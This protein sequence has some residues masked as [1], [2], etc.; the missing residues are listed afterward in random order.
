MELKDLANRIGVKN[1][2]VTH[3]NNLHY[4]DYVTV[5]INDDLV[6]NLVGKTFT[7]IPLSESGINKGL[8]SKS[9][10][11]IFNTIR[12]ELEGKTI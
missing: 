5:V 8:T 2:I 12:K 3:I 10:R 4:K 9:A 1:I 6:V 7:F 11:N